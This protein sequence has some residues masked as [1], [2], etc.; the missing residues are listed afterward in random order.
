M[1]VHLHAVVDQLFGER[2][3]E[4][5]IERFPVKL[6]VFEADL[7]HVG[8]DLS[9]VRREDPREETSPRVGDEDHRGVDGLDD[10]LDLVHLEGRGELQGQL[11]RL[12]LQQQLPE[13]AGPAL[14]GKLQGP[15][16]LP[17]AVEAV[18]H[19]VERP[20][21]GL[22]EGDGE[23][24][25]VGGALDGLEGLLVEGH[26]LLQVVAAAGV[27]LLHAGD[28]GRLPVLVLY[29]G[30]VVGDVKLIIAGDLR[31]GRGDL[32]QLLLAGLGFLVEGTPPVVVG[33]GTGGAIAADGQGLRIVGDGGL[34]LLLEHQQVAVVAVH[35]SLP[36]DVHA[37]DGLTES[38]VV[39]LFCLL[40]LV[41]RLVRSAEVVVGPAYGLRRRLV[42]HR[43]IQRLLQVLQGLVLLVEPQVGVPHVAVGPSQGDKVLELLR[44]LDG[45]LVLLQSAGV[46]PQALEE[47]AEGGVDGQLVLGGLGVAEGVLVRLHRLHHLLGVA[48]GRAQLGENG[49]KGR[50]D[51]PVPPGHGIGVVRPG[52]FAVVL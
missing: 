38:K 45:V 5:I 9:P 37:V 41:E 15:V 11:A 52:C 20:G 26:H 47:V 8:D 29:G 49:G 2:V 23:T 3:A 36:A 10:P 35:A 12:P 14:L 51:D 1:G 32:H 6:V 46:L 18:L 40:Q 33:G 44:V 19:A 27:V 39:V 7:E 21:V 34:K 22:K 48:Q 30:A 24:E 4:E 42:L 43:Q 17:E 25:A 31:G 28:H 50:L 16:P 13:G